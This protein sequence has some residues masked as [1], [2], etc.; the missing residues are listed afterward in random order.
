MST[1]T[2]FAPLL[3]STRQ[4]MNLSMQK[5]W[6][7]GQV[8]A[9]GAR[10]WVRHEFASQE[11]GPVEVIYSFA[12]PRDASLRRFRV[13]GENFQVDSELRPTRE[14]HKFYEEGIRA[15]SLATMARL[16]GDGIVN[17]SV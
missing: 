4:A 9:M 5:L 16:Y 15:G 13:S 7:T 17:L 3:P 1:R 14:A 11:S 2:G 8:L 12:L 10:L 6:L